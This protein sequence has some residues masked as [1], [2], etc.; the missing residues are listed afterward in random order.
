[1]DL[2]SLPPK[3][4][5]LL[6]DASMGGGVLLENGS[7]SWP[8]GAVIACGLPGGGGGPPP[9][10]SLLPV[11]F[12]GPL[13]ALRGGSLTIGSSSGGRLRSTRLKKYS[14]TSGYRWTLDCQ[15]SSMPRFRSACAWASSV[16]WGG[17]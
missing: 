5:V 8:L 14:K 1:M 11:D 16:G 9:P 4:G 6:L 17:A 13:R 15:S 12:L 3:P 7:L 10:A 2:L